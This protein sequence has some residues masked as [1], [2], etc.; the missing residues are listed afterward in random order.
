[1]IYGSL[2][3]GSDPIF[4]S[5]ILVGNVHLFYQFST[6]SVILEIGGMHGKI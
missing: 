1:M 6:I 2:L 5:Q 3:S 4:L